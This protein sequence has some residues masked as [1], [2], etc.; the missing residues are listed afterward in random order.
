MEFEEEEQ[1]HHHQSPTAG[2]FD[3]DNNSNYG[4]YE[5]QQQY[6]YGSAFPDNNHNHNS[7]DDHHLSVDTNNQHSPP[8]YGFGV[9]TPNPDFVTPFQTTEADEAVFSSDGP[10][11][12]DPTQMQEEGSARREWRRF[13]LFFF[14]S[15]P[16][17]IV[18]CNVT[19][20]P[21]SFN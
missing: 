2:P 7:D 14:F 11:L 1:S 18:A 5:S 12:P 19:S 17:I 16:I 13:D 21:C 10:V 20:F 6:D 15:S 3:D 9:S 4:E 8:V